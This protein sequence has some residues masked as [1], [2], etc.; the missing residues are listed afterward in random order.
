MRK[1]FAVLLVAF[2]LMTGC[3]SNRAKNS[4][5]N[6]LTAATAQSLSARQ[7]QADAETAKWN[8][9]GACAKSSDVSGCMLGLAAIGGGGYR[10]PEPTIAP[11]PR[12]LS[13][14]EKFAAVAGALSPLAGTLVT[15]AVQMKQAEYGRD[16]ARDQYAWLGGIVHDSTSAMAAV[17]GSSTTAMANVAINSRPNVTVGGDY[18]QGDGNTVIR[19]HVGDAVGRDQINGT[20]YQGPVVGRDLIGR[21][22]L[23][24]SHV[25]D[26]DRYA[27]PGPYEGPYCT[28][29]EC[30]PQP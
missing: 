23:V 22:Q 6:Y 28:G 16:T 7:A 27:S 17:A 4:Y 30:Q 24:G 9:A 29:D 11:P 15:G 12:E 8:A 3:A 14:V 18:T 21:D 5:E 25:G 19:G 26:N 2:A 13:G 1:S 20:Q 10:A